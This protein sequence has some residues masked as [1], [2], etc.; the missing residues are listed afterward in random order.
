MLSASIVVRS[1]PKTG[2]RANGDRAVP[3]PL[4]KRLHGSPNGADA[5]IGR[6]RQ[7]PSPHGSRHPKTPR[8]PDRGCR[9]RG[10]C[11]ASSRNSPLRGGSWQLRLGS[12][13]ALAETM[14]G[15]ADRHAAGMCCRSSGRYS[16]PPLSHRGPLR[17]SAAGGSSL[18]QE[19]SS[20]LGNPSSHAQDPKHPRTIEPFRDVTRL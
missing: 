1:A 10:C 6:C 4:Q 3:L 18:Y 20:S 9:G 16:E 11:C 2:L 8:R 19:Q 12:R 7:P 15:N 5:K 14:D 17:S 13:K